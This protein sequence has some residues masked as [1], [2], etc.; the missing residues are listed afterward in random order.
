MKLLFV[1]TGNTC[2]SPMAMCLARH[3]GHDAQSAGVRV[4][5]AGMPA[6]DGA[7][8]AM[9]AR[10]LSL[11]AHRSKQVFEDDLIWADKVIGL[12]DAHR[13]YLLD[14]FPTHHAKITALPSPVPDPYGYGDDVYERTATHIASQLE[15]FL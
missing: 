1:C 5:W 2:R 4:S 13:D 7:Q 14:R 11:E 8:N 15:E 9:K 10:G 6:S 12:T 3:M